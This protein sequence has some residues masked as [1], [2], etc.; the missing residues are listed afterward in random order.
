[1]LASRA[2]ICPWTFLKATKMLSAGA[3][4]VSEAG[5]NPVSVAPMARAFVKYRLPVSATVDVFRSSMKATV[6]V[7]AGNVTV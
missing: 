1:M 7:L 4:G 5:V 3:M 2:L 6:P